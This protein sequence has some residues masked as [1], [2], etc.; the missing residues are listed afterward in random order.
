MAFFSQRGHERALGERQAMRSYLL[1]VVVEA[2]SVFRTEFAHLWRTERNGILYQRSLFEDQ[3][4][5]LAS[6]QALDGVVHDLFDDMLGFAGVECH[7]RILGLAHNADFESVG[8]PDVRAACEAKAL[9][10]G[11]HLVVNR[12]AIH[13]IEDV[14]ALAR[15]IEE[16]K[17]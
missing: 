1:G 5:M 4:D 2:W 16:D 7:R 14:N 17:A 8:D 9:R 15:L 3:G 12:R 13:G 11:R 6:E 10:F